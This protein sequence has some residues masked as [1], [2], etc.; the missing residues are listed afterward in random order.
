[1][2]KTFLPLAKSPISTPDLWSKVARNWLSSGVIKAYLNELQVYADSTGMQIKVK[3]GAANVQ[4]IYFESDAEEVQ[5]I[6]AANASNPRIDRVIVRL[7]LP[8]DNIDF[9]VIQGVPAVS[10]VAPA[11]T[12]NSTRWEISLA[13]IYVGA[14]VS[15]IASGNVTDERI[16]AQKPYITAKDYN[17]RLEMYELSFFTNGSVNGLN[18]TYTFPTAF[19]SVPTVKPA[20]ITQ[21]I[22]YSDTMTYPLITNVTT[23]SFSV[24]LKTASGSNFGSGTLKMKF[25]V[26]GR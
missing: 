3:S 18:L 24:T 19:T 20:N 4:A 13:Q 6:A 2:A 5:A 7:D 17:T 8:A 21:S 25:E 14:N 1:M 22:D 11:L 23:T 26:T 9:A 16:Y 10:P 12:Q 15:T